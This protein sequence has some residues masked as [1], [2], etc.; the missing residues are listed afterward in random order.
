VIIAARVAPSSIWPL[1]PRARKI[2][3]STL[4]LNSKISP[5]ARQ[6]Q[7]SPQ[8]SGAGGT[9]SVLQSVPPRR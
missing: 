6:P 1:L 8:K 2:A 9:E 3:G 5:L 7:G 4:N